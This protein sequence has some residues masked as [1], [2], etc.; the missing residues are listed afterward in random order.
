MLDR[1]ALKSEI[2][3]HFSVSDILILFDDS[4]SFLKK[5]AFLL[6]QKFLLGDN[7]IAVLPPM[8]FTTQILFI[9]KKCGHIYLKPCFKT[10]EIAA[11]L[12]H[13]GVFSLTGKRT[14]RYLPSSHLQKQLLSLLMLVC[15]GGNPTK[16][17][18]AET[19]N[20]SL[21]LCVSHIHSEMVERSFPECLRI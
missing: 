12:K 7:R 9:L 11:V 17:L 20:K 3:S 4:L 1:L 18:Y 15:L 2:K 19:D 16:L 10:N 8:N 21:V 5:N 13:Q 14:F 6:G